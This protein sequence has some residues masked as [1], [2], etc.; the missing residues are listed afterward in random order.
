MKRTVG[1]GVGF[2]LILG[3]AACSDSLGP[4][5]DD[6]PDDA[7]WEYTCVG[8]IAPICD[9]YCVSSTDGGGV[10]ML[11]ECCCGDKDLPA[12]TSAPI[13]WRPLR[14]QAMS[15]MLTRR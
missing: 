9:T 6:C 1:C 10:R 12:E 15:L 7:H 8:W 11:D 13:S 5:C 4:D 2:V 14:P 3:L